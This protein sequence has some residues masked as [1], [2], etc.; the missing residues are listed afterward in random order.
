MKLTQN[1]VA[2]LLPDVHDRIEWSDDLKGLGL[3]ISPK[4][5]KSWLIQYREPDS[6]RTRR[7]RLGKWPL[8]KAAAAHE[9]AQQELARVLGGASPSEIR[10]QARLAPTLTDHWADYERLHLPTKRKSSQRSDRSNW[11]RVIGPELGAKKVREVTRKDIERIHKKHAD[12][13]YQANRLLSLLAKLMAFAVEWG[14][15][16]DNP[17]RGIRRFPE[18][19]RQRLLRDEEMQRLMQELYRCDASSRDAILLLI[20]TG[21]R[22]G[23]A[24]SARWRD[25]DLESGTWCIPAEDFKSGKTHT[26]PLS[27]PA[28]ELLSRIRVEAAPDA[29][30]LFP[31]SGSTGHLVDI[32]KTWNRVRTDAGLP[33]LRI[34]DIRHAYATSLIAGGVN[35]RVVQLLLGHSSSAVTERYSHAADQLLRDA[36]EKAGAKIASL[37]TGLS[38]EI[39][40]LRRRRP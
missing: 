20:L 2:A 26:M 36:T 38:A 33:D 13:P 31:S 35:L 30:W 22:K 7:M 39:V 34:H 23:N 16:D 14:L 25:F 37:S 19:P 21:A 8:L 11:R 1:N 9:L 32:K 15:R 18:Q 24:L 4:G 40:P 12:R 17:A 10:R 28:C 29:E 27:A 3:R 5:T 6:R